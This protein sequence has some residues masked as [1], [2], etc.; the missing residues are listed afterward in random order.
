MVSVVDSDQGYSNEDISNQG[1]VKE[2]V[3]PLIHIDSSDSSDMAPVIKRKR[4][5]P[6]KCV[7]GG[8]GA[9]TGSGTGPADCAGTGRAGVVANVNAAQPLEKIKRG[10]GRPRKYGRPEDGARRREVSQN[11]A[12]GRNARGR[13]KPSERISPEIS[14]HSQNSDNDELLVYPWVGIVANI[15]V[16]LEERKHFVESDEKLRSDFTEKGFHP[17]KVTRLWN[18]VSHICFA[19]VEFGQGWPGFHC[20]MKFEKYFEASGK[21]KQEFFEAR[22]LGSELYGWFGREDDYYSEKAFGEFLRKFRDLKTVKEIEAEE[23]SK[24]NILPSSL[25][26]VTE[27]ENMRLRELKLKFNE[28][29]ILLNNL[30]TEKDKLFQAHNEEKQKVQQNTDVQL[31]NIVKEHQKMKVELEQREKDLQEREA[32]IENNERATL[33]QQKEY[34]IVCKLTE[35]RKRKNEELHKRNMDL[36]KQI[37]AKQKALKW[38]EEPYKLETL[39]TFGDKERRTNAELQ[40]ARRQL[41]NF[42]KKGK[43]SKWIGVKKVGELDVNPF[44][45]ACKEKYTGPEAEEK[46]L[47]LCSLWEDQLRDPDWFP[48]KI[49]ALEGV[50]GC[51]EVIDEEDEKLKRLKAEWGSEIQIAVATAFMEMIEYN[52]PTG[53]DDVWELWNHEAGRKATLREGLSCALDSRAWT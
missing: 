50:Y 35:D 12:S 21:D 38:E 23:K 28:T 7:G 17:I 29:S 37:N 3:S 14:N 43:S 22:H 1:K 47:E 19:V 2:L 41:I 42:F 53:T 51:K 15:P 5:R 49:A 27:E 30:I 40:D 31:E 26:N 48:V 6:H 32:G 52:N 13:S 8:V 34:E 24:S 9:S 33:E 45:A 10:R 20:A 36:E 44:H 11:Q 46:A 39:Q 25:S 4:G 18:Y 16:T